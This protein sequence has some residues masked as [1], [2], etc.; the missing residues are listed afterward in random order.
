MLEEDICNATV[1]WHDVH[2]CDDSHYDILV[3]AL[4]FGWEIKKATI[5]SIAVALDLFSTKFERNDIAD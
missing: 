3:K 2:I 5:L 4:E 1:D